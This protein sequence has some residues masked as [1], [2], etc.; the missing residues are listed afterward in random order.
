MRA[1]WV[2][3][4]VA[5]GG[6]QP[7]MVEHV[8]DD[9]VWAAAYQ[10]RAAAGCECKDPACLERAHVELGKLEAAHG[11]MDEAPPGVQK[12][13][14]E[15]DKCWRDGTKDPARDMAGRPAPGGAGMDLA[16]LKQVE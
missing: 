1:V 13:H 11:G 2:L 7:K 8:E 6:R 16:R 15:F 4:L 3:V 12:A 10:K 5:C 14:G 9:P